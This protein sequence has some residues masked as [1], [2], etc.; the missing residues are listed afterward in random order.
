MEGLPVRTVDLDLG[1][2]EPIARQR[3]CAGPIELLSNLGLNEI[4]GI[5]P[6]ISYLCRR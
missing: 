3:A 1:M 4:V 2:I 5:L 6:P